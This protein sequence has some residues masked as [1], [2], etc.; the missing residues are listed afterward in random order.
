M[1]LLFRNDD[2]E[3]GH[4]DDLRRTIDEVFIEET[5]P[6]TN[7][8]IP[9]H[10]EDN[11]IT[12]AEAFCEEV[13]ERRREHPHIF[14]YSLHGYEHTAI[15]DEFY[16]GDGGFESGQL[17]EF[18]GLP[19]DEQRARIG[20]G[21]RILDECTGTTTRSFVPPYATYDDATVQALADEGPTVIS[22]SG[23]FTD[24]YFGETDPFETYGVLH[25]PDDN[26]F[27]SDWE[28]LEFHDQQYLRDEFDAAYENGSLYV[29]TLHY[30]TFSSAER[31]TQ[32]RSFIDYVKRH[33]DVLLM[34]I[35][36]FA[37]AYR[38]ARLVRT[39]DGWT[40]VPEET[41]IAVHSTGS[42]D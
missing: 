25:V 37:D 18:G 27:V 11:P 36:T 32:L 16:T 42:C 19:Y 4:A 10:S 38:A 35:G 23:W 41:D 17:S 22:G 8:V 9:I 1:V 30:W 26:D 34:T 40:Y 12:D 31:L 21:K 33:E 2:L 13:R 14:E 15:T 28:T 7:A 5:V 39:D 24:V 3:P 6:V 29:Q 20:D